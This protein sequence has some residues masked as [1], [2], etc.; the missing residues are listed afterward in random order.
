MQ[1]VGRLV[2]SDYQKLLYSTNP[3]D[4][5]AIRQYQVQGYTIDQAIKA[6]LKDRGLAREP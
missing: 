4:V 6:I 5:N 2:V 3:V 1:C